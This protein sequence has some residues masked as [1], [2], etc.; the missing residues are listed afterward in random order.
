MN[1]PNEQQQPQ[2]VRKRVKSLKKTIDTAYIQLGR[3]YYLIYYQKLYE[4]WGY[5]TFGDYVEIDV[6]VPRAKAERCIRI[7]SKFIK[8]L[9]LSPGQ[10]EGLGFTKASAI[11]S[12]V[13]PEN[14]TQWVE[15][16]KNASWKELTV[17]LAA[18]KAPP[19]EAVERIRSSAPVGEEDTAEAAPPSPPPGGKPFPPSTAVDPDTVVKQKTFYLY[20]SQAQILEAALD[21]VKRSKPTGV[22][23]N[24]ALAHVCQEYVGSR[25]AKEEKPIIRLRFLLAVMEK[26]YG[27][28][29][30]W[31]QS[32]EAAAVLFAAME[33]HQHLFDVKEETDK[34]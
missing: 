13:T 20:P 17:K 30:V 22:P 15:T 34:E 3:D 28:R 21:D 29:F 10:L 23:D 2:E 26:V 6:G 16:A 9:M 18:A 8:E 19:K 31:L 4:R 24:E 14:A 7:W 1:R 32:S 27:G 11:L 5:D 33:E 12:V 25:M